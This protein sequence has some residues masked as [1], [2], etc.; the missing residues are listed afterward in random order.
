[1]PVNEVE[2]IPL[3]VNFSAI[4]LGLSI[5]KKLSEMMGGSIGVESEYGEGSTFYF[6]LQLGIAESEK[7]VGDILNDII[8][9]CCQPKA[10]D[11]AESILDEI[12]LTV[13]A[14]VS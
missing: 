1:M 8:L 2:W 3:P 4:G 5:S 6:T 14:T 10:S 13:D 11:I 7:I 9:E 12:L